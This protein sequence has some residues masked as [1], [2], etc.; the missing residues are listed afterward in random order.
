MESPTKDHKRV[1]A[2]DYGGKRIGVALSDELMLTAQPFTVIKRT[3]IAADI[4]EIGR[5]VDES[6]ASLLIVGMPYNMDGTRG[7]QAERV[8]KF[9]AKLEKSITVPVLAWD[10]RLSTVAV[11]RTLI[12][13]GV[14]REKRKKVV[15]KLSASYI[16]QGY[17]DSLHRGN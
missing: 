13:G 16:L 3:S 1:V 2:L 4:A 12:E 5:I 10:E 15:D 9:M 7:P 14:T 8:G 17:L 11:T 6:G